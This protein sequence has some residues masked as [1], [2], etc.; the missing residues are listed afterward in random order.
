MKG[1]SIAI[2]GIGGVGG[3][4]GAKILANRKDDAIKLDFIS[5]G[6]RAN[7]HFS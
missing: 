1:K 5:R 4:I 7:F 6:S 3:F 2:L